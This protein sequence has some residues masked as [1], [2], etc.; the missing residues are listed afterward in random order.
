[1][2]DTGGL[3]RSSRLARGLRLQPEI[4]DTT[5]RSSETTGTPYLPLEVKGIVAKFLCKSD[6]K[7]L[8][9]VSKQWH[10]MATPLLF[11]QVY[12]SP[13]NKD[14][15]IFS[16]ITKHPV[17]SRSIKKVICDVSTVPDLSHE[18][19]FQDLCNQ[20]RGMTVFLSKKD[21]FNSPQPRLNKFVNAIIRTERFSAYLFPKYANDEYVIEGWQLWQDLAKEER[22]ALKYGRKGMYFSDLCSGLHRL[23]NLQSVIIENDMWSKVGMNTHENFDPSHSQH[24]PSPTLSG[25][26]LARSWVPW[27][28]RPRRS[29]DAGF[30][31]L[32]LVIQALSGTKRR[33]KHFHCQSWVREGLSPWGFAVYH[34]TDRFA[35]HMTIALREIQTLELQITPRR[36]N[37]IDHGNIDALGY[38][39]HLLE[40]LANL[41]YL[42]LVLISAE[43][44]NRVHLSILTPLSDTCYSYSQVFPQRCKWERLERLHLSGLAIDGLDMVFLLLHQMPQLKRVWLHRIDLLQGRWSGVVEALRFRAVLRPWELLSLRGSLRHEGGMWWPCTPDLEEEE[45]QILGE[46]MG[47]AKAGGRHPCLPPDVDD[48]LSVCY[49]QELFHVA[50]LERVRDFWHRVQR[51]EDR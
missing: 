36:Y 5:P 13:R 40:Q 31:H 37:I 38:L 10:A 29:N 12:V 49:F 48:R 22:E 27:H 41:R 2:A 17:I 47:Y 35:R 3:R 7:N 25:S 1:M 8:R 19:Y 18:I 24:T 51:L 4:A 11:D 44:I 15:Q 6:L 43:R 39:P 30:E 34:M 50:G 28:L 45:A 26:P 9:C 42:K 32:I 16:H 20:W 33:V 14:I 46:F 21:P 23:S